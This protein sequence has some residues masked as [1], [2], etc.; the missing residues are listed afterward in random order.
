[1]RRA[2]PAASAASTARTIALAATAAAGIAL[3]AA[4]A[5][6][7][8]PFW[9]KREAAYR[10][11]PRGPFTALRAE[12]LKPGESVILYADASSIGTDLPEERT[13]EVNPPRKIGP[14]GA[15]VRVAFASDGTFRGSSVDGFERPRI[16]EERWEGERPLAAG[17]DLRVGRFL[18]SVDVQAPGSGRVL[19]YDPAQLSERFHGFSVFPAAPELRLVAKATP[20][21]GDTVDVGTSRGLDKRLVRAASL[22]FTIGSSAC[23]LVGFREPGDAGAL[24][25]PVRDA[26]SGSESYGVG[27]YLRVEWKEGDPT[28]I[29][30]FNHA[31]N[32][33]CAYSPYYNC[34]LPPAEN[35][36]AVEVRAG[37]RAPADGAH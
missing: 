4:A 9:A 23:R 3:A 37:E 35:E 28:A 29:V 18:L 27:R 12:Y 25:V 7:A 21:G 34:I 24:F 8:D 36:L 26:T 5:E 31:T 32:P 14:T 10:E 19:A 30:D 6:S 15:A 33:W 1:M 13:L 22:E 16:G 20:A 2:A 11:D 17:D